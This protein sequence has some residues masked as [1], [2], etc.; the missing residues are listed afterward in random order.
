MKTLITHESQSVLAPVAT[1]SAS[2]IA[3]FGIKSKNL[4][5]ILAVD[6]IH[7]VLPH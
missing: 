2:N 7:G 1:V 3:L 6:D 5:K 4:M